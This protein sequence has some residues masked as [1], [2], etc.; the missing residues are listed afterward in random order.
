MVLVDLTICDCCLLT[1][2]ESTE[3]ERLTLSGAAEHTHPPM[4]YG[5]VKRYNIHFWQARLLRVIIIII[6]MSRQFIGCR[7]TVTDSMAPYTTDHTVHMQQYEDKMKGR[8]QLNVGSE[9]K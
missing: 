7:N 2:V 9:Q 6:I 3:P 8:L 1:Y 5:T 4:Q